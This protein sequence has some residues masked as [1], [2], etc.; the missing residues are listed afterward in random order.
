[1]SYLQVNGKCDGCLACMQNCP[2]DAI[3]FRDSDNT[4]TILHNMARCA[5]CGNCLR[6]CP[7]EAVEFRHMLKNRWDE[8]VSLDLVH[9]AVCGEPVCS[10][11]TRERLAE[12]LGD[13]GETLCEKHRTAHALKARIHLLGNHKW[14]ADSMFDN[15]E[16][17]ILK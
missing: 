5:R 16:P 17:G 1:M 2:A 7:Q 10:A 6:V 8:V 9:C 13:T 15:C 14:Q 4:R 12:K 11:A 3:D